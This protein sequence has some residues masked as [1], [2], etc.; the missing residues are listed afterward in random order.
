MKSAQETSV[1]RYYPA[2]QQ[3]AATLIVLRLI[4]MNKKFTESP[5]E[6]I[7]SSTQHS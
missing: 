7:A 5:V 2:N 4:F 3:Q 1:S 6:V